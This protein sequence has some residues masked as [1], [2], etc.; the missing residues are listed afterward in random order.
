[1]LPRSTET[2]WSAHGLL[3]RRSAL[4][5]FGLGRE[6]VL[7]S[8]TSQKQKPSPERR[9]LVVSPFCTIT[10]A[11][12]VHFVPAKPPSRRRRQ[13]VQRR[14]LVDP[15]SPSE[16]AAIPAPCARVECMVPA[17]Q[18]GGSRA[19][20]RRAVLPARSSGPAPVSGT[21]AGARVGQSCRKRV[22]RLSA[23]RCSWRAAV[24]GD[25]PLGLLHAFT[26]V[27]QSSPLACCSATNQGRPRKATDTR[28]S[29]TNQAER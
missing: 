23:A 25:D 22:P 2:W 18:A 4:T 15:P 11:F 20:D 17:A 10:M 13:L 9:K 12:P 27:D 24:P 29:L 28:K 5:D 6:H 16:M 26:R 8:T 7:F 1:M 3:T 14:R 19:A 21:L